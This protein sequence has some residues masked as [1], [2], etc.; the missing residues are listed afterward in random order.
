MSFSKSLL[1]PLKFCTQSWIILYYTLQ[2]SNM[3]DYEKYD[4]QMHIQICTF[5]EY[6]QRSTLRVKA[7][8]REVFF[9]GYITQ[10]IKQF[11]T[12]I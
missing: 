2:A 9:E 5:I 3:S 4:Q 1:N 12:Q 10:N 7:I 11:H 8:Y 6:K